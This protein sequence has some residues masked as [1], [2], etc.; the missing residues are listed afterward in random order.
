[1]VNCSKCGYNMSGAK[2]CAGCGEEIPIVV[3]RVVML[4]NS[5]AR[6]A[7]KMGASPYPV[8][9]VLTLLP[10]NLGSDSLVATNGTTHPSS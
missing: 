7:G 4:A 2:T 9:E 1:M 10:F 6:V 8:E 5:F 3:K